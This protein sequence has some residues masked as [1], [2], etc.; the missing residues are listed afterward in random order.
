MSAAHLAVGVAAAVIVI[1]FA[2]AARAGEGARPEGVTVQ[3]SQPLPQDTAALRG[4]VLG[5]QGANAVQCELIMQSFDGWCSG[6][7][8]DRDPR[9]W[10]V[11]RRVRYRVE[12]RG[13]VQWLGEQLRTADPCVGRV[14]SRLLGRSRLLAAR[15]TL[16][17]ALT[18][19]NAAVRRL[20]AIGLGFRE[21]TSTTGSLV[22]ALADRDPGVRAAAAW[23]LGAV[24]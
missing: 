15:A 17:D 8:P 18:D 10:E 2:V 12:D 1:P 19:A 22:H 24:N 5:I 23:A 4:L 21:D 13:T 11:A 14:A 9:A 6:N 16:L 20:G 7:V 3:A